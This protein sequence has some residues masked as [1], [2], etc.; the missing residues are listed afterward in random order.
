MLTRSR[1]QILQIETAFG[2]LPSWR[3]FLLGDNPGRVYKKMPPFYIFGGDRS[4]NAVCIN[5]G[6]EDLVT[7][8]IPDDRPVQPVL[9]TS[10]GYIRGENGMDDSVSARPQDA[11]C[12]YCDEAL[13]DCECPLC[14]DCGEDLNDC[15]CD[16]DAD[17]NF[18]ASSLPEDQDGYEKIPTCPYCGQFTEDCVC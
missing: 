18:Q 6:S 4:V 3:F 12:E 13:T 7:L 15:V 8:S 5:H 17:K 2:D 1:S 14:W 11:T 10:L 16:G 9:L